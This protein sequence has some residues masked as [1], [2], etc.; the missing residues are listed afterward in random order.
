MKGSDVGH[1]QKKYNI[2]HK[3]SNICYSVFSVFIF[4]GVMLFEIFKKTPSKITCYT[5]LSNI[6]KN[7]TYCAL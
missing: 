1:V 3:I 6:S 4:K 2:S 7:Y 5:L